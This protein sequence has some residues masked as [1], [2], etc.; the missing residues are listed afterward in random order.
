MTAIF[1]DIPDDIDRSDWVKIR[2]NG[3]LGVLVIH[4]WLRINAAKLMSDFQVEG[5]CILFR[6]SEDAVFCRLTIKI[7]ADD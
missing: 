2:V 3:M 6:V 5:N 4:E 1:N 7:N